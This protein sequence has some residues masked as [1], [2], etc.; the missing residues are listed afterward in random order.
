[1]RFELR[2]LI[3]RGEHSLNALPAQTKRS[4]KSHFCIEFYKLA[5]HIDEAY[6]KKRVGRV[7][8]EKKKKIKH[9]ACEN[10]K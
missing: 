5:I 1:M 6:V 3:C 8:K 7:K 4:K 10:N 2:F 9:N